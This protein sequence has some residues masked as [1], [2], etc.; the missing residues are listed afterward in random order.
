MTRFWISLD[1]AVRFV[2]NCIELMQGGEIFVPKI[3]S[4]RMVDLAQVI[5]PDAEV[6]IVGI[7]PGEKLHEI[8]ISQDEAR[9]TVEMNNMFIIQPP[10]SL[11]FGHYWDEKG[12]KLKDGFIYT[13][14]NNT[15]WLKNDEIKKIISQFEEEVNN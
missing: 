12:A 6:K 15:N 5:A 13:S 3:P 10:G 2:I 11:W 7:R 4:M 9:S 8:L 14:N 1:Q